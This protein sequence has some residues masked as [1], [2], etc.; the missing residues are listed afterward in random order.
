MSIPREPFCP[1]ADRL[2]LYYY[3]R[4]PWLL[5][6]ALLCSALVSRILVYTLD[7]SLQPFAHVYSHRA[8]RH[9]ASA[10]D[11]GDDFDLY[12]ANDHTESARVKIIN[13]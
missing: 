11:N 13:S 9:D 6:S 1:V 10:G 7:L 12:G 2:F 3:Y 4:H 8:R 5:G